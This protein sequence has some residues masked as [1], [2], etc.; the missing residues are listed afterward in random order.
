MVKFL[1]REHAGKP[2]SSP[3]RLAMVH[4]YLAKDF[5]QLKVNVHDGTIASDQVLVGKHSHI[6]P[7][8]MKEVEHACLQDAQVKAAISA[9]ELPEEAKVIVEPWAYA[10]DGMND[11]TS[12]TTMVKPSS[13]PFEDLLLTRVVLVLHAHF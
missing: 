4:A 8:Y 2:G 12:R 3:N 10:T 13:R 5:H 9:L 7:E 6:D 1:E 11:M